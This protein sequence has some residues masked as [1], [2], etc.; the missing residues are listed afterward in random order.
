MPAAHGTLQ[1]HDAAEGSWLPLLLISKYSLG[2][3]GD[4]GAMQVWHEAGGAEGWL[5][6]GQDVWQQGRKICP[7][8]QLRHC[9]TI[10]STS[11]KLGL[12]ASGSWAQRK[13]GRELPARQ[14]HAP[15]LAL[16][17]AANQPHTPSTIPGGPGCSLPP[18]AIP[19]T[20]ISSSRLSPRSCRGWTL[21]RHGG[22]SWDQESRSSLS[23]VLDSYSEAMPDSRNLR[24]S[25]LPSA[26]SGA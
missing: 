1:G 5:S 26:G 3:H 6:S 18:L 22:S 16:A 7:L 4:Q 10:T 2:G 8:P 11:L 13:P 15:C 24:S 20:A 9:S 23:S 14:H 12:H 19:Y 25:R 17:P 21:S